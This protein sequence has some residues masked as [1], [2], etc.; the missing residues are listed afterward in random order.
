MAIS[1]NS[2]SHDNA[3]DGPLTFAHEVAAGSNR[4]LVVGV[5]L[6]NSTA[7]VTTVS[8]ITWDGNALTQIATQPFDDGG[9][10]DRDRADLWYLLETDISTKSANVVVTL[11]GSVDRGVNAGV[12]CVNDAKQQA[13]EA[14][15]SA[16]GTGTTASVTITP[17]TDDAWIID[18]A[19]NSSSTNDMTA[20]A[21]QNERWEEDNDVRT[22]GSDK[23]LATAAETTMSWTFGTE[24]PWAVVAASFEEAEGEAPSTAGAMSTNSFYW[25]PA[26]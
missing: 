12:I 3:E 16:D 23:T 25:G 9:A 19:A 24:K 5:A 7:T 6:E 17:A 1:L 20:G 15:A 4:I 2:T 21:N 10:G 26:I 14:N 18:V 8:G 13:P 11:T 22:N